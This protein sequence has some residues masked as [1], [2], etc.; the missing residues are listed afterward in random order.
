MS[1]ELV[2]SLLCAS[3][4]ILYGALSVRWILSRP[5]GNERMR[6]IAG[7]VQEALLGAAIGLV[8]RAKA[9][10]GALGSSWL[11]TDT[12]GAAP[13]AAVTTLDWTATPVRSPRIW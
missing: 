5:T 8:G 12:G 3:A 13:P 9:P 2:F 10:A 4:A 6:E 7:A 1:G 11:Q